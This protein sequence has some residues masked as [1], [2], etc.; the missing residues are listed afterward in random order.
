M[1]KRRSS[2]RLVLPPA[3]LWAMSMPFRLLRIG[4]NPGFAPGLRH[5]LRYEMGRL[6]HT[7]FERDRWRWRRAW[8]DQFFRRDT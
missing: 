3:R 8:L 4:R 1:P 6:S 2:S 5:V 7:L